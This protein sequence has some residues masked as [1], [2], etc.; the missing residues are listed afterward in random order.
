M[1]H[2]VLITVYPS[3]NTLHDYGSGVSS[4]AANLISK[5]EPRSEQ[6][7]C[8]FAQ[9]TESNEEKT[10]Q[11]GIKISRVWQKGFMGLIALAGR[12]MKE[13]PDVVHIQHEIALFGGVHT[14]IIFP[15][16]LMVLSFH[17]V[18]TIVTLHGVPQLKDI[19]PVFVK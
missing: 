14:A 2:Y 13:R 3:G 7:I 9:K 8:V 1:Q 4:Y 6:K 12:I 17:G 16:V 11:N 15:L 5:M 10:L 19:T 18:K